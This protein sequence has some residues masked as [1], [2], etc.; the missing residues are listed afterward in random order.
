LC[1]K[2]KDGGFNEKRRDPTN[3]IMEENKQENLSIKDE[4]TV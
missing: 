2:N 1:I 4:S 3:K